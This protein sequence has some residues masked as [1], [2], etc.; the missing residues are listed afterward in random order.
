MADYSYV[1]VTVEDT[2]VNR[3]ILE[4]WAERLG[5]VYL[6]S[7]VVT[8]KDGAPVALVQAVVEE[9]R[10]GFPDMAFEGRGD[11]DVRA[12]LNAL[13]DAGIAWEGYDGGG[14]EWPETEYAWR[15]GDETIR[16]RLLDGTGEPVLTLAE[17]RRIL[18]DI[19]HPDSYGAVEVVEAVKRHFQPLG[20]W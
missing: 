19:A 20:L 15:P 17:W 1:T 4:N 2:P 3:G 14:Y 9:A 11:N 10:Y 8:G 5:D 6:D 12:L 16:S 18:N 13:M 7:F